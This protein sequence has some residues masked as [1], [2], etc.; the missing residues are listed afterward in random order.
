MTI[1]PPV[2][3]TSRLLP[4]VKIGDATVSIEYADWS[5]DNGRIRYTWWID[6]AVEDNY[7]CDDLQCAPGSTLQEGLSALLSFLGE[8][9]E[10]IIIKRINGIK[11]TYPDFFPADL[12]HWAAKN[13]YEFIELGLILQK[14]ALI[15]E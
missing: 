14:E 2:F 6:D 10:A 7:T 9:A 12:A 5:G 3:I 11:C 15:L 8:F 4:G 13:S 1:Y